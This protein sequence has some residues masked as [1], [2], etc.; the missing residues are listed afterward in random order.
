MSTNR[1]P[2]ST[3]LDRIMGFQRERKNL[4]IILNMTAEMIRFISITNYTGK[5]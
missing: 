4:K 1:T 3:V 5:C 2:N